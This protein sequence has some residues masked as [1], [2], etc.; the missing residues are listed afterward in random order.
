MNRLAPLNFLKLLDHSHE[1][2]LVGLI[3]GFLAI[4][5]NEVG[6]ESL[7]NASLV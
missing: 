2:E 4:E 3:Y 6:S 7:Q 5:R 1:A